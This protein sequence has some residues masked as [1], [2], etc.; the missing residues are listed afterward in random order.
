MTDQQYYQN[1]ANWGSYQYVTLDELVNNYML[2][3]VGDDQLISN[4]RR[5]GI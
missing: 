1:S 2:I 5:R 4:I 3:N